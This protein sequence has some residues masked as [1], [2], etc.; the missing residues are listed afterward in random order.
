M[1]KFRE[2]QALIAQVEDDFG[3]F[4]NK[5]NQA[6]GTRVRKKMQDLKELA[7]AIRQDVQK[8]KNN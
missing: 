8:I 7:Q 5:N 3:K 6:A 1:K 2:L 4:Y